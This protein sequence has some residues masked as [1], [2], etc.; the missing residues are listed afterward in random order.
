MG[1]IEQNKRNRIR[2]GQDNNA[3]TWLIIINAV[4][5]VLVNFTKLIYVVSDVSLTDF[6][7]QVL[8][9]L[10]LPSNID[11]FTSRPWTIFTYMFTHE[12]IWS[13]I[14]SLLWLWG[15]GYILQDLA[16][17]T[18][19]IP[20]YLYGGF[21]G[22]VFF[23]LATNLIPSLKDTGPF[24]TAGASVMAVAIATTILAP[25]Y[26]IFPMLNGGIPLWIL[27][28][29]FVAIDYATVAGNSGAVAMAHLAAGGMGFI[30]VKQLRKGKDWSTWMINFMHW[31]D[32]LFNPEKKYVKPPSQQQLFYKATKKP[33]EKTPHITQQRVDEILDKINQNGY[34][35]L[36]DEEKEFLKK[37]S[38]ED[39]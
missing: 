16:G 4:V 15:F 11:N 10:T 34:H 35:F 29:I 19:L 7:N 36:T 8:N 6:Y 26:K 30:F 27:T 3:L 1:V 13:L 38:Q 22:G 24:L 31:F 14:S 33:F 17:N 25:D 23:L 2:L 12:S 18:K 37:A 32:N 9:W 39:I 20:I 21:I 5:F 28:L